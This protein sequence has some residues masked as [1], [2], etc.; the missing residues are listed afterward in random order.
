MFFLETQFFFAV[1]QSGSWRM[2]ESDPKFKKKREDKNEALAMIILLECVIWFYI[3]MTMLFYI[4]MLT[5]TVSISS[6]RA[7]CSCSFSLLWCW[8]SCGSQWLYK[9]WLRRKGAAL[10]CTACSACALAT[11]SCLRSICGRSNHAQQRWQNCAGK[12]GIA[13]EVMCLLKA[14]ANLKKIDLERVV[15][16]RKPAAECPE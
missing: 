8:R 15:V 1:A 9:S 5:V 3:Y 6:Q 2:Q 13:W 7:H 10:S 14:I 12:R 11:T 16:V 4:S